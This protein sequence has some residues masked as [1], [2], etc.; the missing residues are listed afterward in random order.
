MTGEARGIMGAL[1]TGILAYFTAVID[2]IG[3]NHEVGVRPVH[4]P[5]DHF[6]PSRKMLRTKLSTN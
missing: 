2:L 3:R 5:L 4:L 6:T 1:Q